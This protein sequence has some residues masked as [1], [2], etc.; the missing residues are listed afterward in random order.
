MTLK[1]IHLIFVALS[2]LAFLM[3]GISLFMNS[4]VLDK[5]W[6]KI[7]PQVI[8]TILLVSGIV[9]AMHLHMSP[10]NQPWLMA[11]IMGLV[12][13]IG[14]GVAAFR[15]PNPTVRK[16]LWLSALI[17]F[18]YIISVAVTKNPVGFFG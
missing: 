2:L 7:L 18:G 17:A 12:V 9:L 5:S 10:G 11:K 16:L 13:Y 8:N 1:H 3:R 4:S 14:L 15:V 6:V